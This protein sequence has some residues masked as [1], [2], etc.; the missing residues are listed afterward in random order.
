MT[1]EEFNQALEAQN[2]LSDIKDGI[3]D[4][5][6]RY[7]RVLVNK[8]GYVDKID[9]LSSG[10]LEVFCTDSYHGDTEDYT[11]IIPKEYLLAEFKEAWIHE[12]VAEKEKEQQS[13]LA[14]QKLADKTKKDAWDAAEYKRLTEKFSGVKKPA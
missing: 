13:R 8:H 14:E 1:T 12:A 6:K 9:F 10:G 5:V 3:W 7:Q 4:D 11:F 2:L